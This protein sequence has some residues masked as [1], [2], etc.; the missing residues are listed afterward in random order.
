MDIAR[1]L[2]IYLPSGL[3]ELD[4]P[5][6]EVNSEG[7][8]QSVLYEPISVVEARRRRRRLLRS[9]TMEA[10]EGCKK[11]EEEPQVASTSCSVL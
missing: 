2:H 7:S 10:P 9:E 6:V 1:Q 3:V 11:E 5:I 8:T 4:G